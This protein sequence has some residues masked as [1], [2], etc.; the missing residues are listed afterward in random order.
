MGLCLWG[1]VFEFFCFLVNGFFVLRIFVCWSEWILR[2]IF[3]SD[4]VRMVRVVM[5][6]V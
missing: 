4:V 1:M 3:F 6:S 5:N 2:V